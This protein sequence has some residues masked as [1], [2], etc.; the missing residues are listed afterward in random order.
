MTSLD[1]V[2]RRAEADA[3]S[4]GYFL[5]PNPEFLRDLLEGLLENEERYGYPSCPCR[6]A[7]G[8][9]DMDRDIVCP[10]DY[11]DPD[12]E[13]FGSCYC[14]LYVDAE[15]HKSGRTRPIPERRPVE[16]QLAAYGVEGEAQPAKEGVPE[17]EAPSAERRLMYCRV[18][19]YTVFR[20]EPPYV[21]P[22]CRAKSE[23]FS[24]IRLSLIFR[25]K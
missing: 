23:M 2:R 14:C 6:M 4:R 1:D 10:C 9:F 19:G 21:C 13:E 17:V 24:E 11:R 12:V 8:V 7:S 16:K 20:E 25:T 18:C 5:N 3:R 22:I 15:T